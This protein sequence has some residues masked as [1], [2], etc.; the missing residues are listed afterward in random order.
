MK[1]NC[2][3]GCQKSFE[4]EDFS[5]DKLGGG[6]EKVYFVCP[7]CDK[8]YVAFYTDDEIRKLQTRIRRVQRRFSDPNDNHEDAAKKEAD[9]KQ[10]IKEK[11]G[12]LRVKI[13]GV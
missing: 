6:I 10:Q 2:D 9:L 13:E 12:V 7:H 3:A 8:E 1:T 11:M 5:T 4:F